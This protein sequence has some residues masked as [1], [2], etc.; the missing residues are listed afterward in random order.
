MAFYISQ[1]FSEAEEWFENLRDEIVSELEKIEKNKFHEVSWLANED[2]GG[3]RTIIKG[4]IIK[5]P[6][7]ART[8]SIG[9]IQYFFLTDKKTRNSLT[10]LIS[11]YHFCYFD[12]LYYLILN[13]RFYSLNFHN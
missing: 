3:N 13:L 1:E 5:K 2:G 11:K 4:K 12:F 8:K 7:N 9:I 10:K 6:N